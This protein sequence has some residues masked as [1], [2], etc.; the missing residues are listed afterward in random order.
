[1]KLFFQRALQL[2]LSKIY[3]IFY[4]RAW[5]KRTR[6]FRPIRRG[7]A[8][9]FFRVKSRRCIIKVASGL[10]TPRSMLSVPRAVH[11][12]L[13]RRLVR[14]SVCLSVQ[15]IGFGDFVQIAVHVLSLAWG[16]TSVATTH[17]Y[18][19]RHAP[20]FVSILQPRVVTPVPPFSPTSLSPLATSLR[21]VIVSRKDRSAT[22][23]ATGNKTAP[24]TVLLE[25][26]CMHRSYGPLQCPS[27]FHEGCPT[28]RWVDA[29][30]PIP[31]TW[32]F[33]RWTYVLARSHPVFRYEADFEGGYQ[34][35][36]NGP[37]R[38]RFG[39]GPR[40][41]RRTLCTLKLASVR[42]TLQLLHAEICGMRIN[43]NPAVKK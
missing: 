6:T 23:R 38:R 14:L 37:C 20:F 42:N 11:D 21:H 34:F 13:A 41:W 10:G 39:P 29:L 32:L 4:A 33:A 25:E 27:P 24:S 7:A 12:L 1:M 8:H 16:N 36:S 2:F 35:R 17:R 43:K 18:K 26:F 22:D 9:A 19:N 15:E 3:T 5:F 40:N 30:C 31:K 28:W